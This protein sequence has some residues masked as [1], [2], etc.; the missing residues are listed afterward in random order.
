MYC[1]FLLERGGVPLSRVFKKMGSVW[2]H[3]A[4]EKGA[5]V[6]AGKWKVIKKPCICRAFMSYLRWIKIS[7]L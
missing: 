4:Y 6:R 7:F 3:P 2:R 1:F 5:R